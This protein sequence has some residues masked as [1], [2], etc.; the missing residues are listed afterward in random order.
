MDK[1]VVFSGFKTLEFRT[2]V[3]EKSNR[4]N[5]KTKQFELWGW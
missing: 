5:E 3:Y 1:I 2:T 4:Y